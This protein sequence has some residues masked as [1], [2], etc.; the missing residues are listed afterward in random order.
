MRRYPSPIRNWF[1]QQF[2]KKEL[3]EW[4]SQLYDACAIVVDLSILRK[5]YSN[6]FFYLIF[7]ALVTF[8]HSVLFVVH[9]Y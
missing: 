8:L 3:T 7:K 2:N 6:L 1:E 9:G 5:K 4:G